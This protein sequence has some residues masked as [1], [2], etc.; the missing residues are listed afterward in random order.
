M[1]FNVTV[2][3]TPEEA[4]RFMGLPDVTPFNEKLVEEM[5]GR[6]EQNLALMS[7]DAIMRNWMA[8]GGQA[9]EALMGMMSSAATGA[10]RGLK[11]DK[12]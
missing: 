4:R 10:A 6:M 12:S 5:T 1:K 8:I 2:E 3:C 9:S 11:G 7:P